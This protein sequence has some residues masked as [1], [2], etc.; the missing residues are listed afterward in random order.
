MIRIFAV[1]ATM[2]AGM[3]LA[4]AD[5]V[6]RIHFAEALFGTWAPNADLCTKDDK[7]K[8][9]ISNLKYAGPEG[10][11]SVRWIVETAA[12]GGTN[13]SVHAFCADPSKPADSTVTDLIIRS[14]PN[15]R[16]LVGKSFDALKP[17][18]RCDGA[19]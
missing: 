5:E 2:A 7:S 16:I 15:E 12:A 6:R 3:T 10:N 17:Y 9:E 8:I 13:Y 4:A 11:C 19:K 18:Q 1:A 14:Q